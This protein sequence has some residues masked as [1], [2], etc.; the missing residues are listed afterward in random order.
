[1]K[2]SIILV[3]LAMTVSLTYANWHWGNFDGHY[4]NDY[5]NENHSNVAWCPS[6]VWLTVPGMAEWCTNNC[7]LFEKN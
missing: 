1:M 2:I 5:D 6:G 3:I 4:P 7:N